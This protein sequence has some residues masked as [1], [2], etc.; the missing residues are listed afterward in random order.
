MNTENGT[1]KL[2]TLAGKMFPKKVNGFRLKSY[3]GPTPSK[4]F[5][6]QPNELIAKPF[7]PKLTSRDGPLYL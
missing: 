4:S 7:L 3:M 5:T 6:K 1:F 2:G